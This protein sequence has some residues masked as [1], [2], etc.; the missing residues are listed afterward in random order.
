MAKGKKIDFKKVAM[1]AVVAGAS[2]AIAQI[3]GEAINM[4]DPQNT[5]YI[6][7]VAGAVLPEV[8]K[9]D[10]AETAGNSLIAV[11]AYR[12]AER[13]DLAGKLGLGTAT[14]ATAGLGFD[15]IGSDWNKDRKTVYADKTK[16]P[17]ATS[18]SAVG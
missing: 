7:I 6:L 1:N 9:N 10:L 11:G 13:N 17:K 12:L 14:P 16:K 15:N 3:A 4:T 2:G 5:D 8:I 18:T